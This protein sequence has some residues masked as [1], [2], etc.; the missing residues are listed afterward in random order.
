MANARGTQPRTIAT[1]KLIY[2]LKGESG[3]TP[4]TVCIGEPFLLTEDNCDIAFGEDAGGSIV[5]FDGL[6]EKAMTVHGAD[7][8]QALELAISAA[9]RYL[10]RLSK[11][12]DFYFDDGD[13]Y[14]EE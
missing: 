7:T 13:P 6:P 12:Y 10:R 1:R 8:I 14:F 4:F 3:R 11:K 2:T 5:S 9:D